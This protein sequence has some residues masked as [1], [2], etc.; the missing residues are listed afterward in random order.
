MM[1]GTHKAMKSKGGMKASNGNPSPDWGDGENT[2]RTAKLSTNTK[3]SKAKSGMQ[4]SG[5]G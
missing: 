1:K 2:V 5:S 4:L 3:L